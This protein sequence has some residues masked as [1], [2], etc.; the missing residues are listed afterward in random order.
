[1]TPT[2]QLVILARLHRAGLKAILQ[3]MVLFHLD[4]H[5]PHAVKIMAGHLH[6]PVPAVQSAVRRLAREGYVRTWKQYPPAGSLCHAGMFRAVEITKTGRAL[7][8]P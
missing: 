6:S 4:Q 1:M 3:A 2:T 7:L 5:G 8:T